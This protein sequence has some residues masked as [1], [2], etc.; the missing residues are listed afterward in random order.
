[1]TDLLLVLQDFDIAG[2][3]DG[4]LADAECVK[5]VAEILTQLDIGD[6]K[7]RVSLHIAVL[8]EK[9][10]SE[11]LI[12]PSKHSIKLVKNLKQGFVSIA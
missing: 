6:Y 2:Q 11:V 8:V 10:L 4:M 12:T 1:V 3:Y 9:G 7:I 5:I